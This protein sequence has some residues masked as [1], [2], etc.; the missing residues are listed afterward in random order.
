MKIL[1]FAGAAG[2][3]WGD[4]DVSSIRDMRSDGEH[5][6]LAGHERV[7]DAT[8]RQGRS[9]RSWRSCGGGGR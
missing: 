4:D 9:S 8:V 2:V 1:S 6:M 3:G 7:V 5:A